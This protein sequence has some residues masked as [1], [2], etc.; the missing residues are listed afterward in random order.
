MTTKVALYARV[1]KED[2]DGEKPQVPENQLIPLRRYA[3]EQGYEIFDEYPDHQSGKDVDRPQF[4]QMI[5]DA[6]GHRFQ[7]ILVTDVDRFARS[8]IHLHTEIKRLND[9]KVAVRFINQPEASTD[10]PEGELILGVL[11][12]VAQFERSLISRRTKSGLA[13]ARAQGIALGRRQ[14]AIP[15]QRM[16]ELYSQGLSLKGIGRTVGMTPQGV[17]KRL[18]KAGVTKRVENQT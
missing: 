14:N 1:S 6:L 12:A 2:K 3:K 7:M 4:Q 5:N 11:G 10:T 8:M 17:K 9:H 18:I 15:T 16:L 13:R